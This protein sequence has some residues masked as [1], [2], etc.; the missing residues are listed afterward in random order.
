[1]EVALRERGGIS[2]KSME[3]NKQEKGRKFEDK[4]RKWN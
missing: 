3:E 2:S 4:E 1:M